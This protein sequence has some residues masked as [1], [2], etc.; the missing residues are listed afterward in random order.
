MQTFPEPPPLTIPVLKIMQRY[1]STL[2]GYLDSDTTALN[3]AQQLSGLLGP[4]LDESVINLA[5]YVKEH[6]PAILGNAA[7]YLVTDKAAAV[8]I[9]WGGI[10]AAESDTTD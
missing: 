8:L 10:V 4:D 2:K 7:P 6:G 9:E 1:A 5:A 3:L